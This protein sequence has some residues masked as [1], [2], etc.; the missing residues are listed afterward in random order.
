M[1]FEWDSNKEKAN[2]KKH[3]VTF[4]QAACLFSDPFALNLFD[5]DHSQDKERWVLF[6]KSQNE[7]ILTVAHTYRN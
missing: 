2:I 4:E 6:G 3:G 5:S 1:R 7:V